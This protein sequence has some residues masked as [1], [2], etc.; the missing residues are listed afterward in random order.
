ME[1]GNDF[2]NYFYI[3]SANLTLNIKP[4]RDCPNPQEYNTGV[5]T[6]HGTILAPAHSATDQ[7]FSEIINLARTKDVNYL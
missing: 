3:C 5:H 2:N 1:R 4:S 7:V 6:I